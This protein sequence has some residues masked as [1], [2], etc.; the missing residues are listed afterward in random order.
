M[1]DAK[2]G[3]MKLPRLGSLHREIRSV[4]NQVV[5]ELIAGGLLTAVVL[6]WLL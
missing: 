4:D 6:R 1:F 2:A 5:L 3:S